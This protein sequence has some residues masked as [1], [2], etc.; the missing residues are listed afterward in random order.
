MRSAMAATAK[1]ISDHRLS[2]RKAHVAA[3]PHQPPDEE[4]YR[5]NLV[6]VRHN[7]KSRARSTSDHRRPIWTLCKRP[8]TQQRTM[9]T[10]KPRRA[11]RQ[12]MGSIDW[13]R[14]SR[15]RL[16]PWAGRRSDYIALTSHPTIRNTLLFT[17]YCY[18]GGTKPKD[19]KDHRPMQN[20]LRGRCAFRCWRIGAWRLG[21]VAAR[22]RSP[23]A[24]RPAPAPSTPESHA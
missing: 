1:A 16:T 12:S 18:S 2:P 9:A 20:N 8:G 3:S 13:P 10:Y 7:G 23:D 4:P 21:R 22:R 5:R 6:Q 19:P 11:W 14:R 17:P 15:L 24:T